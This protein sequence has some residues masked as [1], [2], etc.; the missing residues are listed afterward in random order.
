M[1]K[2]AAN[3]IVLF[4]SSSFRVHQSPS[5]FSVWSR[6][7]KTH[8]QLDNLKFRNIKAIWLITIDQIPD[9]RDANYSCEPVFSNKLAFAFHASWYLASGP[10]YSP[11]CP[12]LVKRQDA[13]SQQLLDPERFSPHW[14]VLQ[15]LR[16]FPAGISGIGSH[17][18]HFLKRIDPVDPGR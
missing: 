12:T 15:S 4:I 5:R 16:Q 7:A 8:L 3:R 17:H 9:C 11:A 2:V 18:R 6:A 1:F 10:V 14:E 13:L